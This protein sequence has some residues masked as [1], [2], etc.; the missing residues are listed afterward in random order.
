VCSTKKRIFEVRPRVFLH[1]SPTPEGGAALSD[2]EETGTSFICRSRRRRGAPMNVRKTLSLCML[3]CVFRIWQHTLDSIIMYKKETMHSPSKVS[4]AHLFEKKNRSTPSKTAFP[5]AQIIT[6]YRV[7]GRLS[8]MAR[9]KKVIF[10][11]S[12]SDL[13]RKKRK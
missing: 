9:K 2:E 8:C 3:I 11:L 6:V 10:P 1:I 12:G 13:E 5:A 4:V 7:Q